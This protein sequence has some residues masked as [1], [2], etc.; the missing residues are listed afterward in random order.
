MR[1]HHAWAA[2]GSVAEAMAH[3]TEVRINTTPVDALPVAVGSA[4]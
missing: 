2:R 4:E 3:C 1:V